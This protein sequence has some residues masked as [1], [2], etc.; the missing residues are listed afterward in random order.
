[1]KR[2]SVLVLIALLVFPVLSAC[3]PATESAETTEVVD[4]PATLT[5]EPTDEPTAIPTETPIPEPTATAAPPTDVPVLSEMVDVGGYEVFLECVGEGSPTVVLISG[6]GKDHTIWSVT[7]GNITA[8]LGVRICTYDRPGLGQSD[9]LP[10]KARTDQAMSDELY[11]L[12][13]NADIPGPYILAGEFYGHSIAR[14]FADQHPDDVVGMIFVGS[15]YE[16]FIDNL[17]T[18]VLPPEEEGEDPTITMIRGAFS[19]YLGDPMQQPEQFDLMTSLS[20]LEETAPLGDMPLMVIAND[21]FDLQPVVDQWPAYFGG[22]E[23]NK[24]VLIDIEEARSL[25]YLKLAGLSTE[26]DLI[27]IRGCS[28]N[29]VGDYPDV[30]AQAIESMVEKVNN[31]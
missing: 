1:M 11:A 7:I 27:V 18:E 4:P 25:Q 26:S 30:I 24:E 13:T 21:I 16:V 28:F 29:I 14:I 19:F 12:L 9:P 15:G 22:A 8:S 6:V 17:L 31:Q 23:L 10:A 2:M 3:T 5:E 20:Q